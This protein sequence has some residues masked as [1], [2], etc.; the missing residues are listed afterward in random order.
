MYT[1][2]LYSAH[3]VL[4]PEYKRFKVQILRCDMPTWRSYIIDTYPSNQPSNQYYTL[5]WEAKPSLNLVIL[6]YTSNPIAFHASR[7]PVY[8]SQNSLT[9]TLDNASNSSLNIV[10]SLH[11]FFKRS[12]WLPLLA[13]F[14]KCRFTFLWFKHHSRSRESTLILRRYLASVA[15]L[16]SAHPWSFWRSRTGKGTS[17]REC[18]W[19]IMEVG[20]AGRC[21]VPGRRISTLPELRRGILT[22]IVNSGTL[23]SLVASSGIIGVEGRGLAIKWRT[24]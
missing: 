20:R 16:W 23:S 24:L 22:G 15:A 17:G 4:K 12:L 13:Y 5:A 10:L 9:L 3:Q 7:S 21:I 8:T 2:Q 11:N 1:E 14:I 6:T 19:V 18:S